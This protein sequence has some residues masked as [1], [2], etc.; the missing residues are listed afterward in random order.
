MYAVKLTRTL[1][2]SREGELEGLD[3]HEHGAPAYHPEF[4][5]MGYSN[6]ALGN[7]GASA[8]PPAVAPAVSS[9]VD[10]PAG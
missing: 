1:R 9:L 5:Y 8:G 6:S 10:E 3:I 7:D 2:I 4:Q